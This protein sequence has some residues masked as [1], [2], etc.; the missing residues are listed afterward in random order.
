VGP[1]Q[2]HPSLVLVGLAVPF[3]FCFAEGPFSDSPWALAVIVDS[4]LPLALA[5]AWARAE[6]EAVAAV[7]DLGPG[8]SASDPS[9]GLPTASAGAL[10]LPPPPASPKLRH[11]LLN[12]AA[13]LG[14]KGNSKVLEATMQLW[15]LR[16]LPTAILV[17]VGG[18][19]SPCQQSPAVPR[20]PQ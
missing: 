9:T 14:R 11:A 12:L 4:G 8:S 7:P 13:A 15:A 1:R 5:Q 17:E 18:C 16:T 6:A 3:S 10:V 19:R 2:R 20:V